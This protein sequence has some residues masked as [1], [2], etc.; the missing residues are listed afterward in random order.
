MLGIS[1]TGGPGLP[2]YKGDR[3][4][5]GITGPLGPPVSVFTSEKLSKRAG[6]IKNIS[7]IFF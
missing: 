1:V 6:E 5:P 2:G 3:G 7:L 4:S